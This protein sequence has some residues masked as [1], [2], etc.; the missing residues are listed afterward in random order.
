MALHHGYCQVQTLVQTFL[1]IPLQANEAKLSNEFF[2][3]SF[4]DS[5]KFFRALSKDLV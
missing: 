3:D 1:F 4:V 2:G 5:L